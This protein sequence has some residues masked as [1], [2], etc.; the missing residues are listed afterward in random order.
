MAALTATLGLAIFPEICQAMTS[1][2]VEMICPYDGSKFIAKLQMSGT[3]FTVRFDLRPVGAIVSPWPLAVC[4][5]NGFVFWKKKFNDAELEQ[6]RPLIFSDEYRAMIATKS[7]YYRAAWL[8]DR[9][10]SSH[11]D[12]TWLLLK[13][14]WE[15][16]YAAELVERLP[17]DIA[18]TTGKMQ[19]RLKLLRGELLRQLGRFD[20]A[21]TQFSETAASLEPYSLEDLVI[22]S[23]LNLI[24]KG[25]ISPEHTWS[26]VEEAAEKDPEM[27]RARMTLVLSPSTRFHE[28]YSYESDLFDIMGKRKLKLHW[29]QDSK[30]IA[31]N[32]KG[33]LIAIN[34]E[35]RRAQIGPELL[36][37]AGDRAIVEFGFLSGFMKQINMASLQEVASDALTRHAPYTDSDAMLASPDGKSVI[38]LLNGQLQAR[39]I[40]TNQTRPLNTPPEIPAEDGQWTLLASDPAGPKVVFQRKA[41]KFTDLS[42]VIWD[43][44]RNARVGELAPVLWKDTLGYPVSSYSA[45]GRTLYIAGELRTGSGDEIE[46]C[47]LTAWN[48]QSGQL[49]KK[50]NVDGSEVRLSVS[51]DGRH[52]AL[53]CG[54]T[55]T[56]WNSALD[57][58]LE[59]MAVRTGGWFPSIAFSPD[60]TK[61]AIH[62]VG[63]IRV[64]S[65]DH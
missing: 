31:A 47:Q 49:L 33:C 34:P 50:L 13:A 46:E 42:F 17:R 10:G 35:S 11:L 43:Y 53:S 9:L 44:E 24:E 14:S 22:R 54:H 30:L 60:S 29:T 41:K 57:Q 26:E 40:E 51:S 2:Q 38:Y 32:G 23:E 21:K 1:A 64:Y 37:V 59:T 61:F 55:V 18:E 12:G 5:T 27:K 7:P 15:G 4:P 16:P 39:D 58:T 48:A 20:E 62:A 52:V 56:I 65:V 28:I 19:L 6:L 63:G 8:E 25:D 45:D 3:T 36:A